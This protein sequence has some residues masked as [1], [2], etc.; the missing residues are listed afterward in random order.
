MSSYYEAEVYSTIDDP[1][2]ETVV[3][4]PSYVHKNDTNEFLEI[5]AT[6]LLATSIFFAGLL[7]YLKVSKN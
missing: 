3:F 5:L 6:L 7:N 4:S 1:I 2:G